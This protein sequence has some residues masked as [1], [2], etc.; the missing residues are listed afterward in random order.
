MLCVGHFDANENAADLLHLV[1]A[2]RIAIGIPVFAIGQPAKAAGNRPMRM[3]AF[4][5]LSCQRYLSARVV[6][7]S[8]RCACLH[9][10]ILST[11]SRIPA[12]PPTSPPDA[13]ASAT[14][15]AAAPAA[16]SQ[17]LAQT[18]HTSCRG[19]LCGHTKRDGEKDARRSQGVR[20]K[21]SPHPRGLQQRAA[22]VAVQ[23]LA[24]APQHG[25]KG[26]GVG[27]IKRLLGRWGSLWPRSFLRDRARR[28]LIVLC[29]D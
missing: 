25:Q 23:V 26:G 15:E 20:T 18:T 1:N 2:P 29:D 16:S 4:E 13:K 19:R 24:L 5:H 22:H 3:L 27:R 7:D 21:R 28:G 6:P 9:T 11:W 17:S 14:A 12:S 8:P 10:L